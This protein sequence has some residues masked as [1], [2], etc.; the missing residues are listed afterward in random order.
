MND[1]RS[2]RLVIAAFVLL[3]VIGIGWDVLAA[4]ILFH[5]Y[6]FLESVVVSLLVMILCFWTEVSGSRARM[7][8]IAIRS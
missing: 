6:S 8:R 1:K 5:S 2:P 3:G 7:S 4:A